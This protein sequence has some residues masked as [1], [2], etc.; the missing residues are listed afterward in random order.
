MIAHACG[1]Q[2]VCEAASTAAETPDAEAEVEEGAAGTSMPSE[3]ALNG[4]ATA[5]GTPSAGA[6]A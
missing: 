3:S 2:A 1:L 6:L 5:L 4:N